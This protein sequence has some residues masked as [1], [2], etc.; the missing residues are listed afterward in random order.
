MYFKKFL[1]N[2]HTQGSIQTYNP[3]SKSC[4]LSWQSQ[5]DVPFLLFAIYL[6]SLIEWIVSPI[7][8]FWAENNFPLKFW[9]HCFVVFLLTLW[10]MGSLLPVWFCIL[11]MSYCLFWHFCLDKSWFSI[12]L[13]AFVGPATLRIWKFYLAATSGV[14]SLKISFFGSPCS[15]F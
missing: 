5:P 4:M 9:V 15:F 6:S 13:R 8:R 3:E 11:C 14:I 10:L 7:Q 12:M 2:L 1:H